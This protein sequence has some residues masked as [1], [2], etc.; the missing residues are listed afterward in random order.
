LHR[1][2][3]DITHA[4]TNGEAGCGWVEEGLPVGQIQTPAVQ[5][6][7]AQSPAQAHH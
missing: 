7:A 3:K 1:S 6:T 5:E 4:F 2:F